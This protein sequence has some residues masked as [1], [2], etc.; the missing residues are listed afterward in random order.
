MRLIRF[1]TKDGSTVGALCDGV[2]RALQDPHP[3]TGPLTLSDVILRWASSGALP[4][5]GPTIAPVEDL[6]ILAPDTGTRRN[7]FCVGKNYWDH[8]AE[9]ARSGFDT[10]ALS[11]E[12]MPGEPVIFTKPMSA[13]ADPEVP[14]KPHE[15]LT[16]SLDYEAELA[17][18][19]GHPVRGIDRDTAMTHV[20]GYTIIN[21]VTARDLQ[22]RH[23]QWFLGK[24]L[25][26]SSPM[27]PVV[28]TADELDPGDLAVRCWVNGEL[29][30]DARTSDLLHDVPSLI[31]CIARGTAL[32][33]GDI[34]AT[35]TPAGV[36]IGFDPPRFLA[37]GDLITIEIEGIGILQNPVGRYPSKRFRGDDLATSSRET[38]VG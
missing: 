27:G 16:D 7:V 14:M 24:S 32:V 31:S 26:G 25:D 33:P 12:W 35:G 23:Q 20:F 4:E 22:Q 37:P 19:I 28:V 9:F 15:G 10:G 3:G 18:V 2:V 29:R 13:I 11:T 36:G 17:V 38:H 30:Q 21:D 8:A 5:I 1:A 6:V 34:I